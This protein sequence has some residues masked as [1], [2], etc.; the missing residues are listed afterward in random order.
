MK[1]DVFAIIK[2]YV[3]VV[4]SAAGIFMMMLY[5]PEIVRSVGSISWL[6]LAMGIVAAII[7][8][9]YGKT[10]LGI[11]AILLTC[12][13]ATP[14]IKPDWFDTALFK[15]ILPS[16]LV[17]CVAYLSATRDR[18]LSI[19]TISNILT[20]FVLVVAAVLLIYL[21]LVSYQVNTFTYSSTVRI[22]TTSLICHAIA[23][24]VVLYNLTIKPNTN[25]S[26]LCLTIMMFCISSVLLGYVAN[27]IIFLTLPLLYIVSGIRDS[28]AMAFKDEL[29]GIFGRRALMQAST[30]LGRSYTIAMSD[31]DHFKKFND[32][33]GHYI[34]DE[35]LKIVAAKLD[36]IGGGGK[37]YRYGGEEFTL[38]FANKTPEQ[39]IPYIQ[40]VREEIANYTM[41]IRD[42]DRKNQTAESRGEAEMVPI[43][44]VTCSFGVAQ[45]IHETESFDKV[46]K[47]ADEALY[48]AK[49][50]GRN[51][52]KV[53]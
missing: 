20:S 51:C 39:A 15:E 14:T 1:L 49:D 37:A 44:S 26:V 12:F 38:I 8:I 7:A 2:S 11:A 45:N 4:I 31:V 33:Y 6:P 50:S 27:M 47:R 48:L 34:G 36:E 25:Q 53:A 41:K 35:V 29:T 21:I 18:S 23:L 19:S 32:T 30:G 10:R 43:V 13:I 46:M 22:T 16:V 5:P 28:H 3:F 52:V 17:G 40:K 42:K 9:Q 24:V